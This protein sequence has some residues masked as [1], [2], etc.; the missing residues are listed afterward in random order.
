MMLT[1]SALHA[2]SNRLLLPSCQARNAPK[3]THKPQISAKVMTIAATANSKV[4]AV[5]P[6]ASSK[7]L[8]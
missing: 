5:V 1:R 4:A 6:L 2:T 3:V 8:C 7:A